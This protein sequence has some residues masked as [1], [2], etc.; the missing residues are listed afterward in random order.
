M[1]PLDFMALFTDA[2]QTA[3][4][5]VAMQSPQLLLWLLKLSAANPVDTTTPDVANGLSA[6]AQAGVLTQDRVDKVWSDIAALA[7]P[8]PPLRTVTSSSFQ[9]GE[10]FGLGTGRFYLTEVF[11]LSD[12]SFW[13][14]LTTLCEKDTDLDALRAIH[15][16]NLTA[17]LMLEAA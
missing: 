7:P 15:T 17:Q 10:E 14:P 1:S 11:E 9:T 13:G 6:M 5:S 4:T 3:I 2:E 12:G 16:A 8:K